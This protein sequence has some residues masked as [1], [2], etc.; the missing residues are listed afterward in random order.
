VTVGEAVGLSVGEGKGFYGEKA[1]IIVTPRREYAKIPSLGIL[2]A[3]KK[4]IGCAKLLGYR[5]T[6]SRFFLGK[7]TNEFRKG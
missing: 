3:A 7:K 5:L 6:K 4:G 1:L 2:I